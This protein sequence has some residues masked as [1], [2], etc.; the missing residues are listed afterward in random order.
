MS[1]FISEEQHHAEVAALNHEIYRLT[2]HIKDKEQERALSDMPDPKDPFNNPTEYHDY[3]DDYSEVLPPIKT[4]AYK[5]SLEPDY[6][7]R[8]KIKHFYAIGGWCAVLQFAA[9]TFVAVVI[10]LIIRTLL[11]GQN[12]DADNVSITTY[13]KGSSILTSLNMLIYI[14]ANVGCAMIG[15][16]MAG[17]KASS[18]V[19]TRDYDVGKAIQYCTAAMFIWL[20]SVYISLGVEDIFTKYGYSTEVQDMDGYAVTKLGFVIS[21]VY[22]CI[23]APVTEEFFFRGMLLKVFSKA[24]QRFAVFATAVFFGLAHGNLP[25]FLLAFLLGLFLAHITLKHG[26]IIPS[27]VVHIFVNTFVTVMGELDLSGDMEIVLN[28]S[29]EAL[30]A[31]GLLMLLIFRSKDKLPATTPAQ[32]KRGFAIAKTTVGVVA[33]FTIQTAY[34]LFL[35][36]SKA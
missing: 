10:V 12:P 34:M 27:I 3:N 18:L 33:A 2:K 13:M 8:Q 36:F 25:Q 29:L 24:N 16:K 23:I 1:D 17:V 28:L 6:A 19:K 14:A 26:S 20:V 4:P 5:I 15:F 9:S 11:E 32:S 21:I 22:T 7:E 35:V 30:A 31:F